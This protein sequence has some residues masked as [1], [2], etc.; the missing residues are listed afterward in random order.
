MFSR[1]NARVLGKNDRTAR[2]KL[3]SLRQH[4][5]AGRKSNGRAQTRS[6]HQR[7]RIGM[8]ALL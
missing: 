4:D 2:Q 1:C 5:F 8:A 3:P 6:L 7:Q